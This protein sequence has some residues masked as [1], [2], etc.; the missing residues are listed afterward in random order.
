MRQMKKMLFVF[1]PHAGKGLIKANLCDIINMFT[2][3][4]YE[5]LAYATQAAMDGYEKI[6]AD[7]KYYDTI[8]VSG[9]DGTL[10][11]AVSAIMKLRES[12]PEL[13]I[14]LGYIP[15]GSTNDFANSLGISRRM[16]SAAAAILR[17]RYYNCDIGQFNDKYFVYVAGFG[18][19]TDVS[20]MT[21]QDMKNKLG[22]AAYI[23][24][25]LKAL[26]KITGQ[27]VTVEHDGVKFTDNFIVGL[28]SNSRSIAGMK[29]LI[30]KD[31]VF[32]DG[33]FEVVLAKTPK[34]P[35]ELSSL[36]ASAAINDLSNKNFITFKTSK[37]TGRQC[38]RWRRYCPRT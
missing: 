29:K 2:A 26:P 27:T 20:Y 11:E 36:I 15:A 1:N 22:H 12:D 4:G 14:P 7:G 32:D 13:M 5:V 38:L 3:G 8:V 30:S 9:G 31:V 19:F 28:V 24:E 17:G 35:I 18:A 37:V 34:D 33:L 21:P 25:A 6:V 23:V 16:I 10:S